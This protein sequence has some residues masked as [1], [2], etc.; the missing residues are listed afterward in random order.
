MADVTIGLGGAERDRG[1]LILVTGLLIAVA[2]VSLVFLLNTAIFTENLASRGAD[3]SS[4]EAL[5][6]RATVV[7]GIGDQLDAEN[8]REHPTNAAVRANVTRGI[9]RID[10]FTARNRAL[11]GAVA[12]I[13]RSSIGLVNGKL[14]RQTNDSRAFTNESG[15]PGPWVLG[16]DIGNARAF[17]LTIRD[18]DD[19]LVVANTSDAIS[20][21][22]FNISASGGGTW[23]AVIYRNWST[24]NISVAVDDGGGLTYSCSIAGNRATVDLSRGRINGSACPGL[25]FAEGVSG[26]YTIRFHNGGAAAGTYNLTVEHDPV[27]SDFP[28]LNDDPSAGSPYRVPAVY[29]V[30]I[31]L[32]YQ[33]QTLR[34]VSSVRVAPGESG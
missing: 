13:N 32:T 31:E 2:M 28:G 14:I 22:A 20:K 34:Y 11:G 3:P 21:G 23:Q 25:A 1:Q 16:T 26:E 30:T 24:S 12:R 6:Y 29:A 5:E 4:R 18:D 17:R 10:N 19:E 33:T 15:D 27:N 7:D 8:R 9:R